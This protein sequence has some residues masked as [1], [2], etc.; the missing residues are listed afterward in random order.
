MNT[1]LATNKNKVKNF[2][3]KKIEKNPGSKRRITTGI[4]Y[5]IRSKYRNCNNYKTY[6]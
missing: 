4:I 6:I 1:K 2:Q 3:N 5:T